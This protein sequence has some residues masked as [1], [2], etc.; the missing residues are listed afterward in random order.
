MAVEE[1]SVLILEFLLQNSVVSD[2]AS[3]AF[4]CRVHTSRDSSRA[5][6][7]IPTSSSREAMLRGCTYS[8]YPM[9]RTPRCLP[10]ALALFTTAPSR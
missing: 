7:S 2:L 3:M 4:M 1:C 8:A 10:C 6:S 5:V 9:L